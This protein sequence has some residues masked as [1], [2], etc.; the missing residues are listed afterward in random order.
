MKQVQNLNQKARNEETSCGI[1]Y[2]CDDEK[3]VAAAG[4]M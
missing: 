4:R 3:T 2:G 1:L